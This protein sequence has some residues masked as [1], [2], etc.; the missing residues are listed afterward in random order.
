MHQARKHSTVTVRG[1]DEA[2]VC[3]AELPLHDRRRRDDAKVC[4]HI[5]P[6][7]PRHRQLQVKSKVSG[8]SPTG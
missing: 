2:D 6:Q 3:R 5:V 4:Q 1:D 8:Q 7:R